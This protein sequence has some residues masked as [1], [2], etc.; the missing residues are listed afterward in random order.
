MIPGK[1]NYKRITISPFFFERHR[2]GSN[3]WAFHL[4]SSYPTVC[5]P[6]DG[7]VI[8]MYYFSF[9]HIGPDGVRIARLKRI[10]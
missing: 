2:N 5:D 9:L 3:D 8:R 6:S 1:G 4:F 7:R 10:V